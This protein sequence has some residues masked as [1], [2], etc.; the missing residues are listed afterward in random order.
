MA[1]ILNP[2]FFI[3]ERYFLGTPLRKER[4]STESMSESSLNGELSSHYFKDLEY[5]DQLRDAYY[6][7]VSDLEFDAS[8]R[9][10]S[11]IRILVIVIMALLAILL[12]DS[13]DAVGEF[14]GGTCLTF[15]CVVLP[16]LIYWLMYRKKL[17]YAESLFCITL[18]IV[19]SICGC[20][21]GYINIQTMIRKIIE[22][23][24]FGV[25]EIKNKALV[26][27]YGYCANTPTPF[28]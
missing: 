27:S 10:S 16:L 17:H 25:K 5:P 20:F 19:F 26:Y 7:D 28:L 13:F 3:F 24:R 1:V 18:I 15:S 9:S 2:A 8:T 12:Q 11:F 21:T 4:S 6:S 22:S 23:G 14:V